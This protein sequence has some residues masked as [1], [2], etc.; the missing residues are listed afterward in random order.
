MQLTS[1]TVSIHISY[2]FG[3]LWPSVRLSS[4]NYRLLEITENLF[5]E[6]ALIIKK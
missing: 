1:L 2:L 6:T 3:L 5:D 4:D